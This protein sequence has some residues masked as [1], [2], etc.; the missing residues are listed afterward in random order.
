MLIT[1]ARTVHA[2]AQIVRWRKAS[3]AVAPRHVEYKQATKQAEWDK[4]QGTD[5][6]QRDRHAVSGTYCSFRDR[7]VLKERQYRIC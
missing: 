4:S 6:S 7:E 3:G 1:S 5:F 2:G